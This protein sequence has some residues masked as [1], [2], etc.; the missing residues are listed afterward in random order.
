MKVIS[1]I[2][3]LKVI[4]VIIFLWCLVVFRWCVLNRI[5]KRVRMVVISK[6]ELSYY[7]SM[8]WLGCWNSI[9]RLV[10]IVFSCNVI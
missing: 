1:L 2:I 3:D 4:V 5:V 6:V 8:V 7:G 10:E 9:L